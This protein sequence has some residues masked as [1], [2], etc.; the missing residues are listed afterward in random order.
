MLRERGDKTGN[1]KRAFSLDYIS[2]RPLGRATSP[3]SIEGAGKTRCHKRKR[4]PSEHPIVPQSGVKS[5]KPVVPHT[6]FGE[7]QK[8]SRGVK[9]QCREGV[10]LRRKYTHEEKGGKKIFGENLGTHWQQPSPPLLSGARTIY[11]IRGKTQLIQ[12]H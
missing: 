5:S 1:A 2:V 7:E 8:T 11:T 10:L 9:A 12:D 6:P 3:L 4:R